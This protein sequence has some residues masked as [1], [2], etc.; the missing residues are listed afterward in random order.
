M[1]DITNPVTFTGTDIYF[2]VDCKVISALLSIGVYEVNGV[3]TMFTC[4]RSD[5]TTFQPDSCFKCPGSPLA[6][7]KSGSCTNVSSC[8]VSKQDVFAFGMKNI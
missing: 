8:S 4:F 3:C 7:D 5:G 2:D 1:S 6:D